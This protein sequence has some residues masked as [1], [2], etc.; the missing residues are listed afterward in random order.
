M[1]EYI[2]HK[3]VEFSKVKVAVRKELEA[4]SVD[5]LAN[6]FYAQRKY[7]GCN[8]AVIVTPSGDGDKV[9]SRTGE[10]VKSCNHIIKGVR[11]RLKA[12][13]EK[14]GAYAVLGEVWRPRTT[15]NIISGEF[16][17]HDPAPKL[18]FQ[19]FDMLTLTEFEAGHSDFTFEVRYEQLF[20]YFRG[21]HATDTVQLADTYTPGSYGN[22]TTLCDSLVEQ[23]GYDGLILRN[24]YGLWTAGSGTDGEII[25]V[26]K[27]ETYDLRVVGV[28]EGKGKYKGTL[29]ALVCQGPKGH[30]KVSGMTDEQRDSWWSGEKGAGGDERV[31]GAIVEVACLG[32]TPQGSLR[33]PR[34]KGVRFDKENADFE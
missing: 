8:A 7:D 25:K 4:E 16:R 10:V 24:P 1:S 6:K 2:I 34:F 18:Q 14:L 15:Q 3:A 26:K 23:G 12:K 33:E 31:V 27:A 13:L 17:R 29:G 21:A 22:P 28:E 20:P 11:G 32:L 9:L 5:D 30:V 19:V